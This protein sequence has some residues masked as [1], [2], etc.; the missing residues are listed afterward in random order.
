MKKNK[1]IT[2]ETNLVWMCMQWIAVW[3]LA[4]HVAEQEAGVVWVASCCFLG[5]IIYSFSSGK[6]EVELYIFKQ[7]CVWCCSLFVN[8]PRAGRYNLWDVTV[9]SESKVPERLNWSPVNK[10]F[11]FIYCFYLF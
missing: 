9:E 4:Q 2:L 10:S 5:C 11:Y 8:V 1:I 3:R 7:R 6:Q